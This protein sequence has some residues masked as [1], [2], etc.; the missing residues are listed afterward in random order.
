MI[1]NFVMIKQYY[2]SPNIH[3]VA[4]H[5]QPSGFCLSDLLWALTVV[6]LQTKCN[7]ALCWTDVVIIPKY[8]PAV[9]PLKWSSCN[10]GK[11]K[12]IAILTCGK[13]I[14]V[15][16]VLHF[17]GHQH[18]LLLMSALLSWMDFLNNRGHI[19]HSSFVVAIVLSWRSYLGI[20]C[21][22]KETL[23]SAEMFFLSLLCS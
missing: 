21:N 22:M 23:N 1:F 7:V 18:L 20:T 17:V 16:S 10:P 3:N 13:Q 19:Y 12:H 11:K 14:Q 4:V 9:H 6:V 2:Y 5:S 15:W 8:L